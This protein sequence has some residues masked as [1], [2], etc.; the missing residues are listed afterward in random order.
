MVFFRFTENQFKNFSW[1]SL[2]S[3]ASELEVDDLCFAADFA[4]HRISIS[5]A[6]DYSDLRGGCASPFWTNRCVSKITEKKRTLICFPL[7]EKFAGYRKRGS[8]PE[9]KSIGIVGLLTDNRI[10]KGQNTIFMC[11]LKTTIIKTRADWKSIVGLIC[12]T[13]ATRE[14]GVL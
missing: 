11:R 3:V 14:S 9:E 13:A 5:W 10:S 7:I 6:Y 1:S 4:V 2:I 12:A 8:A